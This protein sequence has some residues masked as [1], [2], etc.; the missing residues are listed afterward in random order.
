MLA[1]PIL[2]LFFASFALLSGE[3]SLFGFFNNHFAF[4]DISYF[5]ILVSLVFSY[6][7]FVLAKIENSRM[8]VDD[9]K[10]H[11]ELTMVH[12]VMV[13][14]YSGFDL[15]LI[16]IASYLKFALF[17]AFIAN[18]FMFNNLPLWVNVVLYF[19]IQIFIA[20]ALAFSEVFRARNKL[21]KNPVYILMFSVISIIVFIATVFIVY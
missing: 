7:I 9:P 6:L 21:D 16:H 14:D 1:E 15:G 10:T 17:G 11:L 8:P 19:V 5:H 12:E 13:L 2:F 4:N 18:L 20:V 3:S